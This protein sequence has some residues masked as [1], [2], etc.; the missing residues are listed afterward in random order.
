[1]KALK[2]EQ[3]KLAA[4]NKPKV[5]PKRRRGKGPKGSGK[6]SGGKPNTQGQVQKVKRSNLKK[7]EYQKKIDQ[8]EKLKE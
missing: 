2:A 6:K 5:K 7:V 8:I 3:D 1:M 4:K